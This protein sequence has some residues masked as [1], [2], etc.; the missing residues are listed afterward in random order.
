MIVPKLRALNAKHKKN[1]YSGGITLEASGVNPFHL[2]EYASTGVDL[3]STSAATTK[4]KWIDLSMR[5]CNSN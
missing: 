5:Y 3:I 4:S 1:I 2:N